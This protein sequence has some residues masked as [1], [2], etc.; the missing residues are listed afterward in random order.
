MGSTVLRKDF[1]RKKQKGGKLDYKCLGPY[2]ITH[3]IGRRIYRLQ[4]IADP[5]K[6]VNRVNSVQLKAYKMVSYV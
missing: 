3:S 5:K 2:R 4:L 1:T 6:T